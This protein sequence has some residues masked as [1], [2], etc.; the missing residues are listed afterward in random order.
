MF[1]LWR[2][3]HVFF[4][5]KVHTYGSFLVPYHLIYHILDNGWCWMWSIQCK[6][7]FAFWRYFSNFKN[8]IGYFS[9]KDISFHQ[10]NEWKSNAGICHCLIG[11][12]VKWSRV[13]VGVLRVPNSFHVLLVWGVIGI[14]SIRIRNCRRVQFVERNFPRRIVWQFIYGHT[15]TFDNLYVLCAKKVTNIKKIFKG[16]GLIHVTLQFLR[17]N[18]LFVLMCSF[19]LVCLIF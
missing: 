15:L 9:F 2:S 14:F 13:S 10:G 6:F 19:L 7:W 16:I 11:K 8:S 4:F 3:V 5:H 17:N 1:F 12:E 18:V